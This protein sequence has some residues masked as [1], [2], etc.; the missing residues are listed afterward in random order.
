MILE[1]KRGLRRRW[2]KKK[3]REWE[4][5]EVWIGPGKKKLKR[6]KWM[7]KKQNETELSHT[8]WYAN[9]LTFTVEHLVVVVHSVRRFYFYSFLV[10]TLFGSCGD[11][12]CEGWCDFFL[13]VRVQHTSTHIHA[14]NKN[15]YNTSFRTHNIVDLIP[16]AVCVRTSNITRKLKTISIHEC[17]NIHT[18][19]Y[20]RGSECR[21]VE[22][23]QVDVQCSDTIITWGAGT[24]FRLRWQVVR[25][26][27]HHAYA[28]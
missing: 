9:Y 10:S 12:G 22:S 8:I 17:L 3:R 13:A 26:L 21:D 6:E 11:A 4:K 7:P 25:N 28:R 24:T 2:I 18:N 1:N 14:C 27:T 15:K 16:F 20:V 5:K 19:L 23:W